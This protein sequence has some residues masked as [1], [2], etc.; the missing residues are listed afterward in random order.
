VHLQVRTWAT[1][2]GGPAFLL[3]HGLASNARLWDGVGEELAAAGHAAIAVDLRGH[4]LSDKPEDGYDVATVAGDLEQLIAGLG[5]DRPVVA[6]QSW[7]ANVALELAWR[8]PHLLRGVA[9]IDGGW[10]ELSRPFPTWDAC[11]RAL[12]PPP[13]EGA[14]FADIEFMIRASHPA[15]PEEG[16]AGTIANFD[17]R[18]DGTVAPHLTRARHMLILRG[19]WEHH[20]S[21]RFAEVT[22]PAL[23]VPADDGSS[24][25]ERKKADVAR[26]GALLPTSRTHWFTGDHDIHAQFPAPLADV[27]RAAVAD[28]FFR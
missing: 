6:G 4:G 18:A 1:E 27:L 12:A 10:L 3:V 24:S 14:R 15:W 5:L 23:L 13:L 28:G 9:L 7:G 21:A 16:I 25:A 19:L 26:A 2:S 22:V 11:A 17:I 8:S 20:P